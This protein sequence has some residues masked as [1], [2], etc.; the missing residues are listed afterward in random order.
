[1]LATEGPYTPWIHLADNSRRAAGWAIHHRV[2][3]HY[4]LVVSYEGRELLIVDGKSYEIPQ[5]GAYL[6]QPGSM[7]QLMTSPEGNRPAW[8]HFDVKFDPRRHEVRD[9]TSFDSSLEGRR[10][11][12]QP[13]SEAVWAVTLPVPV[14]KELA[15]FSQKLDLLA[16]SA[17]SGDADDLL[18]ANHE[19]NGLL[20]AW[21]RH[22][23]PRPTAQRPQMGIE[24][25]VA[26]AEAIMRQRLGEGSGVENFA[27]IAGMSRTHFAWTWPKRCSDARTCPS[28]KFPS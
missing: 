12:L 21:V 16:E 26:R 8:L 11:L 1:M 19:L 6:I 27:F 22:E 13:S 5:N 4:L 20:L 14:P 25:R 2:L 23:R 17:K 18:E 3:T 15:V 28:W 10:H 7:A 9:S 24:A